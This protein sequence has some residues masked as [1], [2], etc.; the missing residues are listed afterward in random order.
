MC[1]RESGGAALDHLKQ[2]P[3]RG[4]GDCGAENVCVGR[5]AG[6]GCPG[7]S[8]SLL[9]S[10]TW[11]SPPAGEIALPTSGLLGASDEAATYSGTTPHLRRGSY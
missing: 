6:A 5:G 1:A 2:N 10:C 7:L 4:G 8:G 9:A 11:L 3:H